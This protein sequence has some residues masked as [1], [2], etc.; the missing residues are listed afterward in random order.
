MLDK[1]I[2][3]ASPDIT[4]EDIACVV[5]VLKTGMLVQGENVLALE[6]SFTNYHKN[7]YAIAVS[8]GTATMHLA[9]KALGIGPGDEVIVPAFS[10]IATA[11]VVELVGATCVF[12]DIDLDTFTIDV[13]KIEAA[14]TPS[15]K[16]IIP[17]H[18]FG[19]AADMEA[20]IKIAEK[21]NIIVLEDSACALGAK[22]NGKSTG[23]FGMFGSFSLHPRKSITS[24]E[25]GM[26][27]TNN[28]E[29][30][31]KIRQLRN[32]GVEMID[33]NMEFVEAGFNYRMTDFQAALVNNQMQR[34]DI[35]L[36]KKQVLASVYLNE[37]KNTALKLPTVP[38]DRNHTWQTFHT[39]LAEEKNQ[40]EVLTFLKK[41]NIGANYGAQCIPAMQYYKNKYGFD[42][43]HKFPNAYRSYTHGI[44]LP[45]YE[46][47][48]KENIKQI[49]DVVNLL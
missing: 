37:L 32:H 46:K 7:D 42:A 29:M 9:L 31:K 35:T 27:L 20:I 14:V 33:G 2:P 41:H 40:K 3:L 23:T 44:A 1:F 18:E 13:S 26:I 24:G 17:V 16:V 47:L 10:Y 43:K 15:T 4:E 19:L 39:I 48:T 49:S 28:G 25:G 38:S 12:V 22:Q 30:D 11:N 6:K 34:I 8:N 36:E 5:K 21:H 45:L